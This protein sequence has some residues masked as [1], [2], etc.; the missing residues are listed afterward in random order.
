MASV[1]APNRLVGMSLRVLSICGSL[2]R[3]SANRAALDAARA[4]L[5]RVAPDVE[6]EEA[7]ELGTIPAFN[8]DLVTPGVAVETLRAQIARSHVVM[9]AA[10]EYAGGVA[11]A[12]KNA[13]DWIVGSGELY[14]KPVVVVSAGTSGG[15][16]ARAS[17]I[18]SLTWQGAHVVGE[19]GIV[20][21]RT[22]S[23]ADGRFT[24]EATVREIEQLAQLAVDAPVLAPEARLDLV[25][26]VTAK[27]RHRRRSDRPGA[28]TRELAGCAESSGGPVAAEVSSRRP[29]PARRFA[30]GLRGELGP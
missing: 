12:L 25:R 3:A 26:G 24:D 15:V 30:P 28:L 29:Y 5:R 10:P 16:N 22:K 14:S 21:P 13:F 19:L 11:G 23:D 6:I 20:A 27:R 9:V 17:I 1:E 4:Y 2:Q 7:V 8:P 18:R